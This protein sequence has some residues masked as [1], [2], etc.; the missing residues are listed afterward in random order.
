MYGQ[1]LILDAFWVDN[2]FFPTELSP[3]S[4][5][6]KIFRNFYSGEADH[7]GWM[8]IVLLNEIIAKHNISDIILQNL[9]TLGQIAK[10][11]G[12]IPVCISYTYKRHFIT[13][14]VQN[15]NEIK[16]CEPVYKT[17]V[18]GGWDFS[19]EDTHLHK[20]ALHYM[21]FLLKRTRVNSITCINNKI[22]VT[23][24]FNSIG[25]IV[26]ETEPNL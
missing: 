22:K 12:C 26:V 20:R 9:G 3:D 4:K 16:H 21:K 14:S 2:K 7:I 18:F 8:D 11:I 13:H 5:E 15:E 6:G 1:T 23:V 19:E 10:K 17:P 24:S 25:E